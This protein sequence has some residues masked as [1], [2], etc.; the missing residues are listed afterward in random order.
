MVKNEAPRRDDITTGD[1][2][3]RPGGRPR[4]S[5]T[6]AVAVSA[7]HPGCHGRLR[8]RGGAL[9]GLFGGMTRVTSGRDR[10]S[11]VRVHDVLLGEFLGVA[12]S[13]DA[14]IFSPASA[15]GDHN[16]PTRFYILPTR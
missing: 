2:E 4:A 8:V 9:E 10:G 7:A 14:K 15:R 5:P 1:H 16:R 3:N 11:V 13:G 12:C 6:P